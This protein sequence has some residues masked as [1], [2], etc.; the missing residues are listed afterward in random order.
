[1]SDQNDL[2]PTPDERWVGQFLEGI[3]AAQAGQRG[4]PKVLETT[5]GP[6]EGTPTSDGGLR[7]VVPD[8]RVFEVW[9]DPK[10]EGAFRLVVDG[11]QVAR[12]HPVMLEADD[13]ETTG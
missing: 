7:F 10:G 1:V 6:I 2:E 4:F 8:G 5:D 11:K 3:Q 12:F 13:D 9:K